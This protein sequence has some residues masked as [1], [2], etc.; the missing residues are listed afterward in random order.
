MFERLES[1]LEQNTDYAYFLLT[2]EDIDNLNNMCPQAH[3]VFLGDIIDH[4]FVSAKYH[5]RVKVLD[6]EKR[7]I[8]NNICPATQKD[9]FGDYLK[10]IQIRVNTEG[11]ELDGN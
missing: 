5:K 10:E 11:S 8:I 7:M 4:I 2:D 1:C 6:D 3:E 9:K